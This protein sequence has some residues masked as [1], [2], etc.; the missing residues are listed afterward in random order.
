MISCSINLICCAH[1]F[2]DLLCYSISCSHDFFPISSAWYPI[3]CFT[4]SVVCFYSSVLL[5]TFPISCSHDFVN[6]ICL[7]SV[8]LFYSISST[9]YS[10]SCTHFSGSVVLA[11]NEWINYFIW[12]G[13]T[14]RPNASFQIFPKNTSTSPTNS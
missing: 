4:V 10:V 13:E 2:F 7:I 9:W 12:H 3:T 6:Q 14:L 8:Q 1:Y 5:I 11:M